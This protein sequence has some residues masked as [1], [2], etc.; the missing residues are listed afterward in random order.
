MGGGGEWLFL[1]PGFCRPS[2]APSPESEK[3]LTVF[4]EGPDPLSR[5]EVPLLLLL[6]LEPVPTG[7]TVSLQSMLP[8]AWL[9]KWAEQE[10]G[11]PQSCFPPPPWG[12]IS[13]PALWLAVLAEREDAGSGRRQGLL[14]LEEKNYGFRAHFSQ[15]WALEAFRDPATNLQ[16]VSQLVFYLFRLLLKDLPEVI[17]CR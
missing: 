9:L 10:E 17:K 2:Q 8:S 7:T 13:V 15:R 16:S 3:Q 12:V 5:Q 6:W 4:A 11:A 1:W 14:P